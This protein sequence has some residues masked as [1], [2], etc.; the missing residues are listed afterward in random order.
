MALGALEA[1]GGER[2]VDAVL[3]CGTLMKTA[4]ILGPL[5]ELHLQC[6]HGSIQTIEASTGQTLPLL[7]GTR[8]IWDQGPSPSAHGHQ[9]CILEQPVCRTLSAGGG[10]GAVPPQA[11]SSPAI[12]G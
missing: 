9:V 11:T 4:R 12:H 8:S 10:G 6:A 7:F 2:E 5:A 1:G 3:C